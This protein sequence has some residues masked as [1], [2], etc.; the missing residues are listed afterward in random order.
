ML[1]VKA[2]GAGQPAP[3]IRQWLMGLP[4]DMLTVKA[5]GAGQP[6]PHIRQ[7]LMGLPCNSLTVKDNGFTFDKIR[8]NMP[9]AVSNKQAGVCV[10]QAA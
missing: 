9:R 6:A 3:H 10:K 7:W 5:N 1:T 4:G 2:N 8:A